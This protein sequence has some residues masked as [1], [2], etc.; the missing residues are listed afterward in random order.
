MSYVLKNWYFEKKDDQYRVW[1]NAYGNERFPE[2]QWIH[3]SEIKALKPERGMLL[4]RTENSSYTAKFSEHQ[5]QDR[6]VLRQALRDFVWP[7]DKEVYE[8]I[9]Y[10]VRRKEKKEKEL[11]DPETSDPCAVL[12][13]S[14]DILNGFVSLD[15]TRK[16]KHYH[17]VS[18]DL[19]KGMFQD[20]IE[21]SDYELDYNFRF[22]CFHKNAFQFDPW[23]EKYAPVFIRNIGKDTIYASTVYGDFEIPSGETCLMSTE[24]SNERV[25]ETH[26]SDPGFEKTTVISH[27]SM[28]MKKQ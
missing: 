27:E 2:G 15:L 13:F 18:Y 16:H 17:T 24:T 25:Y 1:G 12:T 21:V 7:D 3:T 11:P 23:S 8:K 9:A 19:H 6:R 28:K 5:S 22:F 10:A 20:Y 14:S 4:I 26:T